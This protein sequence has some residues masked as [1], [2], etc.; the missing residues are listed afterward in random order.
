MSPKLS[1]TQAWRTK[2][3]RAIRVAEPM[4]RRDPIPE[5]FKLPHALRLWLPDGRKIIFK[6]DAYMVIGHRTSMN[7]REVDIDMSAYGARDHFV[8]RYHAMLL[9]IDRMA[10]KDL[11]SLNGTLINGKVLTPGREYILRDGDEVTLGTLSLKLDFIR[12]SL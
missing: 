9:A 5:D 1:T 11:N 8:S 3:L 12:F 6:T 7:D 10:I 2:P 4:P